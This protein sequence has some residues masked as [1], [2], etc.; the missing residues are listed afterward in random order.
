MDDIDSDNALSDQKFSI[1]TVSRTSTFHNRVLAHIYLGPSR[2]RVKF[3]VDTGSEIN[4]PPDTL[5]HIL[6]TLGINHT[7]SH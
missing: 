3:K 7:L 6:R 5:M 2:H 1:D 4:T